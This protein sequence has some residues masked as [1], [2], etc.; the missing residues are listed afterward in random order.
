MGTTSDNT[1]RSARAE[2][3]TLNSEGILSELKGAPHLRKGNASATRTYHSHLLRHAIE[4]E[5]NGDQDGL[6]WTTYFLQRGADPELVLSQEGVSERAV[7]VAFDSKIKG[8]VSF[9]DFAKLFDTNGITALKPSLQEE[10]Y[11]T[12]TFGLAKKLNESGTIP[13]QDHSNSVTSF[14]RLKPGQLRDLAMTVAANNLPKTEPR[15][16]QALLTHMIETVKPMP[17]ATRGPLQKRLAIGVFRLFNWNVPNSCPGA[18]ANFSRVLQGL[19]G[20]KD[21][22]RAE[23]VA[24]LARG[25]HLFALD[26][27]LR[28]GD[29]ISPFNELVDFTRRSPALQDATRNDLNS[30]L[31]NVG[32]SLRE[33]LAQCEEKDD[34]RAEDVR[35]QLDALDVVRQART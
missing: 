13:G 35:Q 6:Y 10:L 15:E 14:A 25:I 20:L 19:D 9:D 24:T 5:K 2:D 31:D 3:S 8:A 32:R 23:I 30:S 7:K 12:A 34:P 27:A 22:D 17:V 26:A 33:T 28:G 18:R 1:T 4:N 21:S 16:Q 11:T 29:W